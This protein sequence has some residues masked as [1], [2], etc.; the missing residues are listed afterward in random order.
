MTVTQF[1]RDSSFN[2]NK[3]KSKTVV[4]CTHSRLKASQTS[5]VLRLTELRTLSPAFTHS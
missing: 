2:L 4:N 3:H 5:R 1:C